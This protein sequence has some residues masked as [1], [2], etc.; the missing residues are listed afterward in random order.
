MCPCINYLLI[1]FISV[2]FVTCPIST[3]PRFIYIDLSIIAVYYS[4]LYSASLWLALVVSREV[5]LYVYITILPFSVALIALMNVFSW[6]N[7]LACWP[8]A[9]TCTFSCRW[10]PIISSE[11]AK[12]KNNETKVRAL[13]YAMLKLAVSIYPNKFKVIIVWLKYDG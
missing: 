8:S 11:I 5:L 6:N 1:L 13:G 3:F 7:Q 2:T 9:K 10:C 12:V 4:W